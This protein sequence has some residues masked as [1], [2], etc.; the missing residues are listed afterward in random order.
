MVRFSNALIHPWPT[1]S[2]QIDE[3][4]IDIQHGGQLT[5][6]YLCGVN[7]LGTVPVLTGSTLPKSLTD[8]LDITI[9]LA[10]RYLPILVPTHLSDQ[11]R[12]LLDELHDINYFSLTYTNKED[13]VA[14]MQ[15]ALRG[16]CSDPNIS[17]RHRKA[18]E[19]KLEV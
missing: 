2:L 11:I 1:D 9:F 7:R 4:I 5:E 8:S 19:D 10:E 16:A 3:H 18:L 17:D 13:R 15:G 14:E 12:P 6:D